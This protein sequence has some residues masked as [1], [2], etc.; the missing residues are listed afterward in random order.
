MYF[1]CRKRIAAV[2]GKKSGKSNDPNGIDDGQR[3]AL[4]ANGQ[5]S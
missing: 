5:F 3:A 1:E 4:V 2:D